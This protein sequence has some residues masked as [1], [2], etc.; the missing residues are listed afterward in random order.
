MKAFYSISICALGLVSNGAAGPIQEYVNH[1]SKRDGGTFQWGA[2]GDSYASG[3]AYKDS[4][5]YDNNQGNCLRTTEAYANQLK[6][7]TSWFNGWTEYFTWTACSGSKLVNMQDQIV[8]VGAS[9]RLVTMTAGGNDGGSSPDAGF[10]R[11]VDNCIF[12]S[13]L[14]KDYG[15]PYNQDN[16]RTGACAV[17]IDA[18]KAYIANTI[19]QDLKNTINDILGKD[20]VKSQPDFLLYVTGYAQFFNSDPTW[21]NGHSFA[22]P[23]AK[24]RPQLSQYVR[25]DI[26]E[27]VLGLNTI[28][29]KTIQDFP[30]V[31]FINYD[32]SF[33]GKSNLISISHLPIDFLQAAIV[34][35][36]NV[37]SFRMTL[38][39]L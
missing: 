27:L 23:R 6:E 34:L 25:N 37:G 39:I 2:I 11:V 29:E 14:N 32:A 7:D 36:E 22:D 16:D 21:C 3:V 28:Y 24:S 31:R 9:P 30:S 18:S 12:H 38:P 10:F 19:G 33:S 13:D 5:L 17:S 15:L 35:R 8:G 1:L 4:V 20:N 26:N